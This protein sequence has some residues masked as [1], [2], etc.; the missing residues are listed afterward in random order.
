MREGVRD[1]RGGLGGISH[2]FLILAYV[3]SLHYLV[4]KMGSLFSQLPTAAE[5]WRDEAAFYTRFFGAIYRK[6]GKSQKISKNRKNLTQDHSLG[7][8]IGTHIGLVTLH[9][10][11]DQIFDFR[12]FG[13]SSGGGSRKKF[14]KV[15]WVGWVSEAQILR[16]FLPVLGFFLK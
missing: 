1:R 6:S 11:K 15:W 9:N 12:F 10:R 8:N 2:I 3:D 14:I 5:I 7:L 13:L 16:F 4:S